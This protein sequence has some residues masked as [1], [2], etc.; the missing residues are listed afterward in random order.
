MKNKTKLTENEKEI[1]ESIEES[2]ANPGDKL[3]DETH[4]TAIA[5]VA[6]EGRA[7]AQVGAGIPIEGL[8]DV[9][10]SMLPIPFVKL[11]Q[12]SS[13]EITLENGEDAPQGTFYFTDLQKSFKELSFIML[14]AKQETVD[15]ERDGK[16]V[17]TKMV[18]ILGITTATQKLFILSLSVMSFSNFGKLIAKLRDNRVTSSWQ[19]EI[20]AT[21]EKK[22]NNKGK[23]WVSSFHLGDKIDEE[24]L[25][26]MSAAY[27]EYGGALDR[28]DLQQEATEGAD[29]QV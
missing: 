11:V 3:P 15:F 29:I 8:Q 9:S 14:R 27:G 21:A 7:L 13:T 23:F 1:Q 4:E 10:L 19:Y 5:T 24:M 28:E 18:K 20:K 12:G 22:E 2:I 25:E 6:H 26:K 16:I 17:P